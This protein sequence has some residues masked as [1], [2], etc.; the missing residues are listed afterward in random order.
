MQAARIHTE[1]LLS[2]LPETQQAK[3]KFRS[4][5]AREQRII[6]EKHKQDH[7]ETLDE[8]QMYYRFY[9]YLGKILEPQKEPKKE[10]RL[11]IDR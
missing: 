5:T 6:N 8:S 7:G 10:R 9:D 2:D 3:R 11:L 1:G 4:L